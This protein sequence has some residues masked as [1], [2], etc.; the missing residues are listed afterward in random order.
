MD[1]K[2][3]SLNFRHS[4]SITHHSYF[5]THH[6]TLK[7]S[8]PFAFII[9][10]L[11]LNIFD[12]IHGPHNC[13]CV[14]LFCF[15]TRVPFFPSV[16]FFL[17]SPSPSAL[18]L[19]QSRNPN[20]EKCLNLPRQI[21][22][23]IAGEQRRGLRRVQRRD[24]AVVTHISQRRRGGNPNPKPPPSRPIS[25]RHR[26]ATTPTS[27]ICR[28]CH[29]P[30][31]PTQGGASLSH[32]AQLRYSS[33]VTHFCIY[34]C[35]LLKG[36]VFLFCR[37]ASRHHPKRCCVIGAGIPNLTTASLCLSLLLLSLSV[38]VSC[39]SL[40]LFASDLS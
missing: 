38:F 16:F 9:Q 28:F 35:L 34:I 37:S 14:S 29:G 36:F 32:S 22:T 6:S 12:T 10:F 27:P 26:R 13:H 21:S 15:V 33:V 11:S 5:I 7:F 3:P 30:A 2:K 4:I 17:I 39:S 1:N 25:Q 23:V 31:P 18:S 8:H 20:P 19:S 24:L 40:C